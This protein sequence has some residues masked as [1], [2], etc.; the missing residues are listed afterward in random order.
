MAQGPGLAGD[1]TYNI[2]INVSGTE[3]A[4]QAGEQA[5]AGFVSAMKLQQHKEEHRIMGV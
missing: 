1:N 3:N 2:Q 5:A 4:Y